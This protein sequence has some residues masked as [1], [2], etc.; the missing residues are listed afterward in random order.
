MGNVQTTDWQAVV[1]RKRA[2]RQSRLPSKWS[3]D[4]DDLP[5]ED[6]KDVTRLCEDRKWLTRTE[7]A[8]TGS[9]VVV[10]AAAIQ[11]KEYTAV[12]VVEAFAHRA[13]IAQQL[14]NA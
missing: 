8:I 11:R 4:P 1:E 9:T 2:Q 12:E 5:S 14:V 7:L 13:T 6:V 3:V 10:L